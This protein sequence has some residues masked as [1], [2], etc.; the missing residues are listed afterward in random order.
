[1]ALLPVMP[2]KIPAAAGTALDINP[3]PT[4]FNTENYPP[5]LLSG[6]D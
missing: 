6:N 3:S 1:M 2:E 5:A 4:N